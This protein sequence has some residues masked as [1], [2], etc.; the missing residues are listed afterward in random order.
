MRE[1]EAFSVWFTGLPASG[2]TTLAEGVAGHLRERGRTVQI[3]DSDQL[4]AVLTPEPTYSPEER[5]WF[6]GAV[7][8]IARLLVQNG[9]VVL[10]AATANRR[11]F[12]AYAQETIDYFAEVYVKCSLATCMERDEKGIYEKALSGQ[13]T[14]VPGIQAPYEPPVEPAAVVD[15]EQTSPEEGVRQILKGLEKLSFL[16]CSDGCS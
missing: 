1:G 6:Y 15:T 2:K 5:E 11:R 16:G 14:T 8:F 10:I 4:R 12:R 13:A 7:A 9:V 3:L